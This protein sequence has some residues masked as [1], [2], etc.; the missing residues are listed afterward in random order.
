ME[1]ASS[2]SFFFAKKVLDMGQVTHGHLVKNIDFHLVK[3]ILLFPPVGFKGN[4]SLLEICLFLL[5]T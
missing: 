5:E 4:L 1:S 3:N 2:F